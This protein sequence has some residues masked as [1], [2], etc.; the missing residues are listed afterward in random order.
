MMVNHKP[1]LDWMQLALDEALAPP[2]RAEL[3][4]HLADCAECAEQWGALIRV[5]QLLAAEPLAAPRVG[6]TGRFK[7]RL[8]QRHSRPKE[9]WGAFALGLGALGA[10]A[11]VLPLG[12]GVLWTLAQIAGQPAATAALINSA[13][14][15]SDVLNT[16][17]EALWVAARALGSFAL[18][19][20]TLWLGALAALA[21]TVVWFV[22]M[23]RLV[24]QGS[25]R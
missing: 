11:L 12:L 19:T 1:Y 21:L 3:E 14:A 6:F 9:V 23:G 17:G 18:G 5:T 8:A 7:A 13:T 4:T 25:L 10:S 15:T 20:P 24:R 22:V 2:Q 16:F